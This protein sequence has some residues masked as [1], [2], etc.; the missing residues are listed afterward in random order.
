MRDFNLDRSVEY[1]RIKAT[2]KI[3]A[4]AVSAEGHG[5]SNPVFAAAS[6]I[7][8]RPD[9]EIEIVNDLTAVTKENQP[10]AEEKINK[11]I[12]SA[13]KKKELLA[14]MLRPELIN[15]ALN[16][17]NLKLSKN[18]Y[19][20]Y[21]ISNFAFAD[22]IF[23]YE[24][25]T[26]E[27][28]KF[29]MGA[30]ED[31]HATLVRTIRRKAEDAYKNDKFDEAINFFNETLLKYQADFTVYYQ[32]GLIY[33]FEK[34][35]FKRAME[36]F[37]LACKYSHNKYNLT[38]IHSIVFT[39]LLLRLYAV[40]YQDVDMFN[41]AY[42]AIYQ[43]YAADTG[44]IF[45]KYALAQCTAAMGS[46][47]DLVAQTNSLIKNLIMFEKLFAI[48]IIYDRAFNSFT[49]ELDKLFKNL[50]NELAGNMT[51]LF[52]KIEIALEL[53][54]N[55][56]RYLAIPAKAAAIKAEYKKI[57]EQISS[58]KTFYD[59]DSF[60]TTSSRISN[61][62]EELAKEIERNKKYSETRAIVEAAVKNYREDFL[63]LTKHYT[64]VENK[65]ASL[66][67]QYIKLDSYYPNPEF[68]ELITPLLNLQ[69]NIPNLEKKIWRDS[70]LFVLIK[71]ISG[72]FTFLLLVLIIIVLST[73]FTKGIASLFGI[74]A[75][76]A[77]LIFMPLYSTIFA[78][79]YFNVIEIK[80]RNIIS[81]LK[82]LKVEIDVNKIKTAEIEKK[83][84]AKYVALITEQTHLSSFT[85][86][87]MFEACLEGNFE[88]I[89]A[90]IS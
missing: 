73:L 82:K 24:C 75:I 29:R 37:R 80:R 16:E 45:S 8:N 84:S 70:G 48:Q 7:V 88:Q 23:R 85:G 68:D 61:E 60:Y 54:S 83:I 89:K 33:F 19:S 1:Q 32:L 53:I 2:R 74:T 66:K 90:L 18:I 72:G 26:D 9:N 50:Y 21:A 86:E 17:F 69:D 59:L 44:Y 57:T 22:Y 64:D 3:I 87:K 78:E 30:N 10:A 43:A 14:L 63:E 25:E 77:S 36:N 52:E 13:N 39:G 27:L 6:L 51:R 4:S 81:D 35:D 71:I 79:I 31:P 62:L 46:R 58:K 34:A 11:E 55:N 67:E 20:I 47:N 12:L 42:Q 28:K 76:L 41:E 5:F 56:Q 65:F 49:D 40:E 38:F 15:S